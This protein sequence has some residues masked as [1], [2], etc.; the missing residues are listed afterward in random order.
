MPTFKRNIAAMA[1]AASTS[2]Q[3]RTLASTGA[4]KATG[5]KR[6][7]RTAAKTVC[8]ANQIARLRMTPTTAAVIA[9]SAALRARL[10]RIRSMKGAPRK[11]HRKHGVKVTQ[12]AS[13]PP[14]VPASERAQRAGIAEGGHEADELQDH[15]QRTRRRLGH[16]EAVEHLAGRQPA[17]VLDRLLRHVGEH[18]IGAAEGDHRHDREEARDLS[19]DVVRSEGRQDR[20]DRDEPQ[21]QPH[22]RDLEAV[23]DGRA[24]MRGQLVAEQAVAVRRSVRGTVTPADLERVESGAAADEADQA[25]REHDERERHVEKEDRHEGGGGD[26]DHDAVL[27]RLPADAHDRVEDDGEHGR[28][29]PEEQGG[30]DAD[31]PVKGIDPAQDH[32]GDDAG[33][34]EQ[35]AGHDAAEGAVHQPA[36]VG[37]ELLRLGPRQQHAVVE[38]VQEAA[39]RHPALLLD[40]DAVHDRD[41]AGRAAEG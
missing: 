3:T 28:L 5:P 4:S 15:D 22:G 6:S 35:P 34:D 7:G 8:T 39:L 23:G 40:E 17:V 10:P 33:Q 18:R 12:V 27:Q 19:E 31:L 21:R 16:A 24:G 20:A 30:D 2:A 29:E 11:I 41:L 14:R 1:A 13:S 9:D 38:R 36:D 25:G 37:G 26:A 32:D